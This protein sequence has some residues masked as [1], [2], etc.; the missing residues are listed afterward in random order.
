M[1]G[2]FLTLVLGGAVAGGAVLSMGRAASLNARNLGVLTS[3]VDAMASTWQAKQTPESGKV[4]TILVSDV[5]AAYNPF[6]ISPDPASPMQ[7][8][9]DLAGRSLIGEPAA[10]QADTTLFLAFADSPQLVSWTHNRFSRV[11]ENTLSK[12]FEKAVLKAHDAG[13]EINVVA[14]GADAAPVLRALR[15]LQKVERGGQK[16]GAN[17]V[18][19]L[20]ASAASLA[21]LEPGK[22]GNVFEM[23][24]V[25]TSRKKPGL[26][27]MDM[28]IGK[29]AGTPV[30]LELIWPAVADA[31]H[32]ID[33][34]LRVLRRSFESASSFDELIVKQEAELAATLAKK[35]EEDAAKAAMAQAQVQQT[36][37]VATQTAKAAPMGA[38][39][40]PSVAGSAPGASGHVAAYK[41]TAP[42]P[43][44]A[45]PAAAA[46]AEVNAPAKRRGPP[47]AGPSDWPSAPVKDFTMGF[48][49]AEI[50]W[51][52]S[53]PK[54]LL[55]SLSTE[56]SISMPENTPECKAAI[57][58]R[59]LPLTMLPPGPKDASIPN[60]YQTKAN[61]STQPQLGGLG[62]RKQHGYQG[63]FYKTAL[64][65]TER[66]YTVVET[67]RHI[68][69]LFLEVN[70][71]GKEE[72]HETCVR[73][74]MP[75]YER[76]VSYL[77]P[78]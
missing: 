1:K 71:G 57:E 75:L 31:G 50:G 41:A 65:P 73:K 3:Q 62:R 39:G 26:V 68:V 42:P 5:G 74:H 61:V 30:A 16:V 21:T 18:F 77:R 8:L 15:R 55:E 7:K 53:A 70:Y 25:W 46:P 47:V 32:T 27:Q 49:G 76:I 34:T 54:S 69:Y 52:V 78:N 4:V 12:E 66:T 37:A 60:L 17:K 29:R 64:S 11:S 28:L 44:T 36:Q 59:A 56:N 67:D 23:G 51:L 35:A 72:T 48:Q 33:N 10:V 40:L 38:G 20:G 2:A 14:Q 13:A 6:E 58:L 24:A 63:Y 22:I 19:L 45:V 9:G 43:G